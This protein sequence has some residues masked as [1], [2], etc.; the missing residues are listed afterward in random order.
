MLTWHDESPGA[1]AGSCRPTWLHL[2]G[3]PHIANEFA[4]KIRVFPA[5]PA[6]ELDAAGDINTPWVHPCHRFTDVGGREPSGKY[7]SPAPCQIDNPG[8]VI[9][10]TRASRSS[11]DT[12]IHQK[13]AA[14]QIL[15]CMN[16]VRRGDAHGDVRPIG[17]FR[18]VGAHSAKVKL[19]SISVP[20]VPVANALAQGSH[21]L[22]HPPVR[23]PLGLRWLSPR[24]VQP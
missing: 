13:D 2:A 8:P 19:D 16:I 7:D 17:Q 18:I 24:P 5:G 3:R 4:D 9:S 6:R 11:G 23:L 22:R 20:I 21:L 12:R 1:A 15:D 10:S 14:G